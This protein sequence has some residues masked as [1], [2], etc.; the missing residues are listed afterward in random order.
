MLSII[1]PVYNQAEITRECINSVL[2]NT[3]TISEFIIIDNGSEPPFNKPFTGF[4]ESKLIRN[5]ENKGFPIAINQGI[6]ESKG[7]IIV[8]LNNDVIVTPNW[9]EKLITALNNYDIVGPVTNYCAGLQRT[10]IDDYSDQDE[11]NQAAEAWAEGNR[12]NIQDVNF[13][14]GFCMAFKASL[15]EELG[16][17]DE[18]IWPCCGEEVDFCFRAIE[19]GYRIG[20]VHEC[21]V[22]HEGSR[23]FK[24][25]EDLKQLKYTEICKK[26]DEYINKKWGGNFWDRQAI[27]S[28]IVPQGL[29]LNLGCG[30]R[31]LEGFINIDNRM[32]VEPDFIFDVLNRLPYDDN[33]VDAIRADDFLE[34]IPIG[35]TVDVVTEIWRVLKPGGLFES[36]TPDAE[37]GQGAYQDPAHLSFWVENSWLYYTDDS[38]RNLYG[39]KAKFEIKSLE[40]IETGNRVFHL[41]VIVKKI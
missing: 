5:D 3:S 38:S 32:E 20:I 9:D 36:L 39:I 25:M 17:F 1:I 12:G 18:S 33:S 22:H 28:S 4:I 7:D 21:Y 26:T 15:I 6:K 30:Y 8:L 10:Q 31:K 37:Y 2:T 29:C 13:I 11:L 19:K 16:L 34:H 40:R 14:I 35:K 27:S 41:H 24:M 23:T